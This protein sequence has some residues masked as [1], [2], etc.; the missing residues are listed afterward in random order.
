MYYPRFPEAEFVL[1]K[2]RNVLSSEYIGAITIGFLLAQVVA[3]I[4]SFVVQLLAFYVGEKHDRGNLFPSEPRVFP[5]WNVT[6]PL[7]SVLLYLI[8]AGALFYWLYLR[9]D[10][11]EK[12]PLVNSE[13]PQ[14]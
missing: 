4:A 5:W 7:I 14:Q 3:G 12:E 8:A 13:E 6:L 2:I 9:A 1:R 11:N 10:T